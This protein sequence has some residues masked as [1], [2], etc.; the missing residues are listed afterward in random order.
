MFESKMPVKIR[1]A[2]GGAPRTCEAQFVWGFLCIILIVGITSKAAASDASLPKIAA[3]DWP[4]NDS[5]SKWT[6][7]KMPVDYYGPVDTIWHVPR[8]EL[9]QAVQRQTG[10]AVQA[11]KLW[12]SWPG[13]EIPT[14]NAPAD[15]YAHKGSNITFLLLQ[16]GRND[17]KFRSTIDIQQAGIVCERPRDAATRSDLTCRSGTPLVQLPAEFDLKHRGLEAANKANSYRA[18]F[19]SDI[20]YI[21]ELGDALTT[22]IHCSDEEIRPFANE[23]ESVDADCEQIFI[24]PSLNATARVSYSREY[25]KDWRAIQQAWIQ[26][27]RSFEDQ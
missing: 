22:F 19:Y 24:V 12:A 26:K 7:L 18:S 4:L 25:L 27:L 16:S 13:M 14:P 20:F 9:I 23:T 3:I 2:L 11:I 1:P 8:K 21:P 6:I 17:L 10:F 5:G 15:F